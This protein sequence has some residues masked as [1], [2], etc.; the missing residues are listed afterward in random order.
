[1]LF[2]IYHIL[3]TNGYRCDYMSPKILNKAARK[4]K[5]T[6]DKEEVLSSLS[7]ARMWRL[8]TLPRMADPK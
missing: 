7:L 6:K 1:M 8:P 5:K 3:P 2:N 4:E